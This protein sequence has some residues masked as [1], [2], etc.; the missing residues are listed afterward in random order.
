MPTEAA[1]R[2]LAILRDGSQFEWYVV[3]LLALVMYVYAVEVEKRRW[4]IVMAGLAFWGMDWFNEIWNGLVFHFSQYAPMWG[5]PADT[6]YLILIGL[7]VEIMFMFAIAGVVFSKMLPLDKS[8]RILG[9]PNR[10][11]VAASGSA[12]CVIVEIW[13]NHI[14]ALTWD[15]AWWSARS[16]IPIFLFGYL[17]FFLVAFWVYDMESMRK[18]VNVVGSI[19]VFNFVCILVFGVW[20]GW[21]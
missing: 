16:P 4:D 9:L 21:I 6:A 12:F 13:L 2:A 1:Q 5:A 19:Y 20:L 14:G 11:A 3:P 8:M 7:N 17:H 15:W 10:L 18:R